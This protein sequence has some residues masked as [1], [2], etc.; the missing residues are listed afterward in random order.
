MTASS[1]VMASSQKLASLTEQTWIQIGALSDLLNE[2]DRS[3]QAYEY[4]LR[5]N[6]YSIQAL[7]QLAVFYKNKES[8]SKAAEYYQRAINI[9]AHN[10]ETWANLAYCY[11]MTDEL[12][13]SYSAYQQA[14]YNLSNPR[15]PNMWYGI[16][17]LYDRYSSYEHAE[18]A[19]N[20]VLKMDPRFEKANDIYFRLGLLYKH[21]KKFETSVECLRYVLTNR[22]KSMTES[23]I[24]FEIGH[25][26]ECS[27]DIASAKEVYDKLLLEN[28]KNVKCLQQLGWLLQQPSKYQN[29]EIAVHL[30]NR[31][32]ELKP[33]DGQVLY[34]LG[35]AYM[36][37]KNYTK[38]YEVFQNA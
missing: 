11:L 3:F 4:A 17:R 24:L 18:E 31:C 10:G 25:V 9:E 14:L 34:L 28:S 13:K 5:H 6:P 22:P 32:L 38:A 7:K 19:Y 23:D 8:Y 27:G 26:Y 36:A 16:A 20:A 1:S 2:S 15:D 12:Q 21:Q 37:Q 30:L 33:N 29:F 35:R